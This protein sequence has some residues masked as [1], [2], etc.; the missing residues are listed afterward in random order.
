MKVRNSRGPKDGALRDSGDDVDW[1]GDV[2]F[3]YHLLLAMAK[4][5]GDPLEGVGAHSIVVQ[6][7]QQAGVWDLV[8]RLREVEQDNI[9]L[10]S[11]CKL[12]GDLMNG[13][14]EL[15]LTRALLPEAVLGVCEDA[16]LVK[17]SHDRA[18]NDVFE[19][20]ADDRCQQDRAVFGRQVSFPLLEGRH[21][22]SV[23]PVGRYFS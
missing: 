19:G 2:V 11:F 23:A 10:G 1:G 20:L 8:K 18:V 14:D 17:V 13:S 3:Q 9:N 12:S 22:P 4:E 5:C 16:V 6:F 15:S 21:Y 7:R